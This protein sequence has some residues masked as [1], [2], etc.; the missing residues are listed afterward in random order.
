MAVAPMGM[1]S[2]IHHTAA[3]RNSPKAILPCGGRGKCLP[4]RVHRV[5]QV[6]HEE[7]GEE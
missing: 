5:R 3:I 7:E 2:K 1:T 4:A 6:A